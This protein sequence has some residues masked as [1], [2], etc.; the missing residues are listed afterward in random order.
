DDLVASDGEVRPKSG[1]KGARFSDLIAGHRFDL[2]LD[3]TAR[4]KDP[5]AYTVVGKPLPRPDVPAKCTSDFVYMQDFRLPGMVHA[6]VIRPPAVG[7]KLVSVDEASIKHLAGAKA[8]QIKDFIAV[9]ADDEWTAVRA[10]RA[11]RAQWSEWAGLP[12]QDELVAALRA[13]PGLTDEVL[14]TKGTP[15][16]P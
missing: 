3:P 9:I 7:A 15:G 2:K 12:A 13:D 1:G 5:A 10:A 8:V 6:R 16:A 14:L 11:L 4:F